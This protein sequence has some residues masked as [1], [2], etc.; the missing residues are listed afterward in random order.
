MTPRPIFST[1]NDIEAFER[2]EDEALAA[3]SRQGRAG[4]LP[5]PDAVVSSLRWRL[6]AF[7]DGSQDA[8]QRR[9]LLAAIE[10]IRVELDFRNQETETP[11]PWW[12]RWLSG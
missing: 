2:D 5:Y 10:V 8:E 11:K 7:H 4:L 9:G 3:F 12:K 6:L 1:L